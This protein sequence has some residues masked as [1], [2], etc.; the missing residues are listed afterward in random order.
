MKFRAIDC[1]DESIQPLPDLE[2][3]FYD[4]DVDY[5]EKTSKSTLDLTI[6]PSDYM[7]SSDVDKEGNTCVPGFVD[8]GTQYGWSFGIMF[9]KKFIIAYDFYEEKIGFVRANNDI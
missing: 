8:H 2:F 5:S 7:I 9:L 4:I 1:T 3:S 6:E